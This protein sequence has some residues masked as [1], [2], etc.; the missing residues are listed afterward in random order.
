M[1]SDTDG[2]PTIYPSLQYRDCAA[3]IGW[4]IGTLGFTRHLVV[5]GRYGR[6]DHAELRFG[7][8]LVMPELGSRRRLGLA[9]HATR[10]GEY[11]V[12]RQ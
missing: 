10:R 6:I 1:R 11:F 4:L 5:P 9:G 7:N 12:G 8:G 2:L 3:A